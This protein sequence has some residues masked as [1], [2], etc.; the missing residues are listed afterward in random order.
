MHYKKPE[1]INIFMFPNRH[2]TK[3]KNTLYF[4][5]VVKVNSKLLSTNYYSTFKPEE[6][7][8]SHLK[9]LQCEHSHIFYCILNKTSE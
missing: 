4:V 9:I 6:R 5:K 3:A 7:V 8:N 1:I 2:C